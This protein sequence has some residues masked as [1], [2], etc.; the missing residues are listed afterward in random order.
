MDL[1]LREPKNSFETVASSAC[2]DSD[3][4]YV[5]APGTQPSEIVETH[6]KETGSE[7]CPVP[8]V[9]WQICPTILLDYINDK[10]PVKARNVM[11]AMMKM[12]KINIKRIQQAYQKQ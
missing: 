8:L 5:P 12:Q 6:E 7:D 1:D 3:G 2:A 9:P 4:V 10:N 11:Q